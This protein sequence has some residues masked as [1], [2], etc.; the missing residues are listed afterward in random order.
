MTIDYKADSDMHFRT[1]IISYIKDQFSDILG[2]D[3]KLLDFD[4]G[5][6]LITEK[7]ETKLIDGKQVVA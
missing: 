2:E 4:N 1:S 5:L 6:D 7:Y 3:Q